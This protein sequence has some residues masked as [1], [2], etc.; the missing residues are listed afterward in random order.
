[1][2]RR[3]VNDPSAIALLDHLSGRRLGA[4]ERSGQVDGDD[5]VPML[6]GEFDERMF[7]LQSGIVDENV[8][9]TELLHRLIH[10]GLHLDGI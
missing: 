8:D 5:L 1:M 6:D 9:A 7:E 10:H 3:D 4:Q 2:N